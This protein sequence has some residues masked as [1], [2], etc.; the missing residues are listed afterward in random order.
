MIGQ[1]L[2]DHVDPDAVAEITREVLDR[3]LD[4]PRG[5]GA[6][7]LDELLRRAG[8]GTRETLLAAARP[9]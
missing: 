4:Y 6:A 3:V 5:D 7:L 1:L 8:P 2:A 9:S